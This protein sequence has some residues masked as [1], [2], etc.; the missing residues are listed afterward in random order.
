MTTA[1]LT[2]SV[3]KTA[4]GYGFRSVARMEWLKLRS[5][6]STAWV[7]LVFAA[8]LIGLAIL[9]MAH[10]H[11][12]TMSAENRASFDPTNDSFAGL[13]IGQLA[14]GVLGVLAIT[15]EFSSGMIR[16]TLAAVPRRPLLL[17]AKA[18]VVGA[19]TLVAGEI[20]A[21]A[22]FAVG[23]AVLRSP[24]PHATLGQPGVL[25]AVLMAG[26]YPGLIALIG[27]GL[28]AIIRH[29]A[30]AICAVVGILFVL[31]LILLPLGT[32]IQNSVGQF[33]PM[34]IAEN[35]LTAVK[36]Q[37]HTLSPGLGLR[38]A[39]PV[40]GDR[41]S[42]RRLGPGPPRRITGTIRLM[43]EEIRRVAGIVLGAPLTRRTR[44]ELLYCG[45]GGLAGVVGFW[46]TL[47]LLAAGF[48]V[49]ASIIGTV[50]GLLVLT[51][52]L[53]VSRRLGSLHRRLLKRLLGH[54][55]EAPLRFQPGSGLLGRLDRRLRDRA[56][57]RGVWYS[58]I[59]L[60]VAAVQLYAVVL[61]VFGLVDL[62][63]PVVWL[64]FRNGSVHC[65]RWWPWCQHRS[66][67]NFEIHSWLGTFPAAIAGA[68]CVVAAAWLARGINAADRAWSAACSGRAAWP[69]GSASSSG[70]GRWPW[71]TRPRRCAGS[72][73]TCTTAPRCGW[74]RWP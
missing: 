61:T 11:W 70:P 12:A 67:D 7:L 72:S 23:E 9:V 44:R 37:S 32:S 42:R 62:S 64:L 15:T 21:F 73:G 6:R 56:A 63:Y 52:A 40:R 74:P 71:R 10:Q 43:E 18:A 16:A 41:P 50:I 49:S 57:W 13:A 17:A 60:P 33:M 1:T 20:L 58:L 66:A 39:V 3:T 59:K 31:P 26:A 46:L 36:P 19:V 38:H 68:A 30:G 53:R 25:R 54:Q 35:S 8:G 5:V 55:V 34:L 24:A 65:P 2:R 14:L 29:T 47:V 48:T 69:S 4:G 27:L 22:A 51:V 45:F 28:G